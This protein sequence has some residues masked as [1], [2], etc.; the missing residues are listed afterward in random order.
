[1]NLYLQSTFD[2]PFNGTYVDN[3]GQPVYRVDTPLALTGRTATIEKAIWT[4]NS[5]TQAGTGQAGMVY[6]KLAEIEFHRL[7]SSRLRF[8]GR[9]WRDDEIFMKGSLGSVLLNYGRNHIFMGPVMMGS[10]IR[11]SWGNRGLSVGSLAER[12]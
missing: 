3:Q 4:A 10:N 7:R 9:D 6:T 2:S 5:T 11:G 8:Q 12:L 1:M